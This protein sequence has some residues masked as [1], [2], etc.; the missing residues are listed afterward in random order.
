MSGRGTIKAGTFGGRAYRARAVATTNV[1]I[2]RE[3]TIK[4][5]MKGQKT[6]FKIKKELSP[7]QSFPTAEFQYEEGRGIIQKASNS[8]LQQPLGRASVGVQGDFARARDIQAVVNT[9]PLVVGTEFAARVREEQAEEEFGAEL[10]DALEEEFGPD[11][12][13][14]GDMDIG[15]ITD[16]LHAEGPQA[17][18]EL[19]E[20]EFGEEEADYGTAGAAQ[21]ENVEMPD[22]MDEFQ[23]GIGDGFLGDDLDGL[24]N[25]LVDLGVGDAFVD[26]VDMDDLSNQLEEATMAEPVVAGP[27]LSLVEELDARKSARQSRGL[28][29]PPGELPPSQGGSMWRGLGPTQQEIKYPSDNFKKDARGNV[30]YGGVKTLQGNFPPVP[31]DEAKARQMGRIMD[32]RPGNVGKDVSANQPDL[33]NALKEGKNFEGG[34]T[35]KKKPGLPSDV[36]KSNRPIQAVSGNQLFGPVIHPKTRKPVRQMMPGDKVDKGTKNAQGKFV[37]GDKNDATFKKYKSG[38]NA[39]GPIL[40]EPKSLGMA[41]RKK[42][43]EETWGM[44]QKGMSRTPGEEGYSAPVGGAFEGARIVGKEAGKRA[45]RKREAITKRALFVK[46]KREEDPDWLPQGYGSGFNYGSGFA[47]WDKDKKGADKSKLAGLRSNDKEYQYDRSGVVQN[48]A[49]GE[50]DGPDLSG[51]SDAEMDLLTQYRPQA[52]QEEMVPAF[53]GSSILAPKSSIGAGGISQPPMVDLKATA[54]GGHDYLRLGPGPQFRPDGSVA[55]GGRPGTFFRQRDLPRARARARDDYNPRPGKEQ[56]ET[57]D[58]ADRYKEMGSTQDARARTIES[59]SWDALSTAIGAQTIHGNQAGSSGGQVIR[60]MPIERPI[61][62]TL[63]ADGNVQYSED[64][65]P[66]QVD[67]EPMERFPDGGMEGT[68]KIAKYLDPYE[69]MYDPEGNKR[70]EEDRKKYLN[71]K[72]G[73]GQAVRRTQRND[74]LGNV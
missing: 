16:Q 57:R 34:A 41:G 45:T 24:T 31:T 71:W 2:Q 26:D 20:N 69:G 74:L 68:A 4:K 70:K 35:S 60:D 25:E 43:V 27:K 22:W 48:S 12:Q 52:F 53:P 6:S 3:K 54:V 13:G 65:N 49:V 38:R 1:N 56:S 47:D 11:L 8:N 37:G 14:E 33:K 9:M 28:S 36:P 32:L 46:G 58:W 7:Y 15:D 40:D 29:V 73:M 10:D 62:K 39:S 50:T 64:P 42:A 21:S 61:W 5:A 72:P 55:L 51:V 67:Y 59:M 17:G 66:M 63:D 30:K 18:A 19:G 23:V 44:D